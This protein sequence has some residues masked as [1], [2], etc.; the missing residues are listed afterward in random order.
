MREGQL[1]VCVFLCFCWQLKSSK[2]ITEAELSGVSARLRMKLK[3]FD[4]ARQ[5]RSGHNYHIY[6]CAYL[7][8]QLMWLL[9]KVNVRMCHNRDS[10]ACCQVIE[11]LV[12]NSLPSGICTCSSSHTFSRLLKT[13]RFKQAFSSP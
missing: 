2:W 11:S 9:V 3:Q 8:I 10:L 12:W 6:Y 13:H 7:S 4:V 1:I 5:V